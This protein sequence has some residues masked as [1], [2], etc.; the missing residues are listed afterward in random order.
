MEGI[1]D[2][3]PACDCHEKE[4]RYSRDTFDSGFVCKRCSARHA[5]S[6][7]E[8]VHRREDDVLHYVWTFGFLLFVTEFALKVGGT[9]DLDFVSWGQVCVC[10][11]VFGVVRPLVFCS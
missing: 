11:F 7:V 2:V 8:L 4:V 10:V 9:Q 1:A 6:H 5:I 3:D